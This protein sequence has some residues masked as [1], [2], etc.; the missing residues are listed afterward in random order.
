M[1]D[2]DGRCVVVLG[3]EGLEPIRIVFYG[4]N[5]SRSEVSASRLLPVA[6]N[7]FFGMLH[8]KNGAVALYICDSQVVLRF[9]VTVVIVLKL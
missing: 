9:I 6:R 4:Q 3:L 8:R 5:H 2:V 7:P 1:V